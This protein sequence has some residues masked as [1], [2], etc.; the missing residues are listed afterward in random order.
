MSR[1][2]FRSTAIVLCMGALV[3][4]PAAAQQRV[5]QGTVAPGQTRTVILNSGQEHVWT[6]ELSQGQQVTIDMERTSGNID[7]YLE[8]LTMNG[9]EID[10][11][12]DGGR[13]LNSRLSRYLDAGRY[14]IVAREFGRDDNG[15]YRLSVNAQGSGQALSGIPVS[16]G[17]TLDSYITNGV[18]QTFILQIST[19]QRVR[20]DMR[21]S[22]GAGI[23]PYLELGDQYGNPIASND[24]GGDGFNSQITQY[25]QPG[26]YAITAYDLGDN[27]SGGFQL[28]VAGLG[29]GSIQGIPI[30]VGQTLDSYINDGQPQQFTL[31][32]TSGQR[33]QIDMMRSESG[34]IDPYLV[35]AD[36][37]GNEIESNDDGGSGFD[38]RITRHLDPGTYTL[39]ARD[40]GSNDTGS[41]RMAVVSVAQQMST[42]IPITVG[43]TIDSYITNGQE[44]PFLLTIQQPTSVVITFD[45]TEGSPIDPILTLYDSMGNQID[46]DDDGGS[47]LNSRIS[48]TLQPGT[49]RIVAADLGG[50]RTG[51]FRLGV[52][53]GRIANA[54]PIQP[55]QSF[56]GYMN[57]GQTFVYRLQLNGSRQVTIEFMRTGDAGFDPYLTLSDASGNQITSDDDGGNGLNSRIQTSLNPGTYLIEVSDRSGNTGGSYRVSVN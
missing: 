46:R 13:G 2:W 25:L 18:P 9:A 37:F 23:D 19:A 16:V 17:Q 57:P 12:D 51:A 27:D 26:R 8:L 53:S 33:V 4:A 31:T 36:Q 41:F 45:R 52:A 49:Y 48:R 30:Q 29:S 47:G 15:E 54:I 38:S 21:R 11:N 44:Q 24:D 39:I 43:Q 50:S 1:S 14:Q 42:G 40:L 35:L 32:V 6:L 28:Q 7:P 5:S 10:T 55:G 3:V 22:N 34:G 20:I 56:D